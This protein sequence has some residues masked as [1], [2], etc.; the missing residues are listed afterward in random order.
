M[1]GFQD[2]G[3]IWARGVLQY[4]LINVPCLRLRASQL[5]TH[6]INLR[7]RLCISSARSQ[8]QVIRTSEIQTI[9]DFSFDNID[10]E[11]FAFCLKYSAKMFNFYLEYLF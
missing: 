3:Y 5:T 6:Y 9:S 1:D 2:G 10:L 7:E 4:N 8:K 11:H